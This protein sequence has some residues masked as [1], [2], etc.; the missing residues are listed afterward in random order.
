MSK[1]RASGERKIRQIW[2]SLEQIKDPE[3]PVIS[4]VELGVISEVKLEKNG[5]PCVS[6]TP[7]F[8]GCPALHV[9]R[10]EVSNMLDR[11]GYDDFEVRVVL[12]PRWSTDRISPSG[13]QKLR[14]FGLAPPSKHGGRLEIVLKYTVACPYCSS[15]DT[16]VRNPFG[17]TP[18]RALHFC[19]AC[20]QPFEEFKPL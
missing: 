9:M 2:E 18:C 7:T 14:E 8:S 17:P 13:R 4:L 3:I 15:M 10:Q 6:I 11:L 12:S 20:Q 5:R 1:A 19:F 16:E